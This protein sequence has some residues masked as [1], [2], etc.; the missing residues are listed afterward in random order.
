MKLSSSWRLNYEDTSA[1][2]IYLYVCAH[3]QILDLLVKKE[4]VLIPC[5]QKLKRL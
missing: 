4:Q 3:T 2:T 5:T 1:D